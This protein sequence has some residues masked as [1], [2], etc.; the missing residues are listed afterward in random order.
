MWTTLATLYI[1][2]GLATT[3][4]RIARD[5]RTGDTG[6]YREIA[7]SLTSVRGWLLTLVVVPT[8]LAFLL[9]TWPA[10]LYDYLREIRRA[11]D[12]SDA[13]EDEDASRLCRMQDL[14]AKVTLAQA[15]AQGTVAD[16][17]DVPA[18]P[19]GHLNAGWRAFV[20]AAP[21]GAELWAFARRDRDHAE[22]FAFVVGGEVD[23]GFA[24]RVGDRVRD[25][26]H[27]HSLE[28]GPMPRAEAVACA[29]PQPMGRSAA[30]GIHTPFG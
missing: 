14:V 26:G 15:E 18:V 13:T 16:D 12:R 20:D 24:Y 5:F 6:L 22:G 28:G 30:G 21:P 27:T 8:A 23:S 1:L 11:D 2:A 17:P 25:A 29:S 10:F 19:F 3:G 7:R 4:V 9:L